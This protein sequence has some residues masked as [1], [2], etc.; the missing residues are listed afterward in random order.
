MLRSASCDGR[1]FFRGDDADRR[2]NAAT[3]FPARSSAAPYTHYPKF[4]RVV[5]YIKTSGSVDTTMTKTSTVNKSDPAKRERLERS[6]KAG[7][8]EMC[9]S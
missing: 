5:E 8:K 1:L 6:I 4:C 7:G 9:F 3:A 2:G